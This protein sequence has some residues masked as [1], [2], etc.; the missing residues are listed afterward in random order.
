MCKL[1]TVAEIGKY[2]GKPVTAGQ[3]AALGSGCAWE[4]KD[5]SDQL[6]IQIVPAEY[7]QWRRDDKQ[8][9]EVGTQGFVRKGQISADDWYAAAIKGDESIGVIVPGALSSEN[10]ATELLKETLKRYTKK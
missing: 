10:T 7:H 6:M 9:A 1:F 8:L 5:E 3:N 4:T 2:V